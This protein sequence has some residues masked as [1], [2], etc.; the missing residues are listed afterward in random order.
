MPTFEPVRENASFKVQD[1]SDLLW[2]TCGQ[3]PNSPPTSPSS[4]TTSLFSIS[5]LEV[6]MRPFDCNHQQLNF[7]PPSGSCNSCTNLSFPSHCRFQSR[8]SPLSIHPS[9]LPSLHSPEQHPQPSPAVNTLVSF[10]SGCVFAFPVKSS[11]Q[12]PPCLLMFLW[13][14]GLLAWCLLWGQH[15]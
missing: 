5:E 9:S 7:F 11:S 10:P 12:S 3:W 1:V 6:R 15:G 2:V 8:P 14:L 13:P 4:I